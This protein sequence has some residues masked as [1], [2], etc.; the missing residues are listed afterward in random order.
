MFI[1]LRCETLE[2]SK[3]CIISDSRAKKLDAKAYV[4]IQEAFKSRF[5]EKCGWAQTVLFVGDLKTTPKIK[6]KRDDL[7]S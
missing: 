4:E 3:Y 1:R 6:R 7:E 2:S 5:K